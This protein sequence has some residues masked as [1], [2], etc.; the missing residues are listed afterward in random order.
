MNSV[1]RAAI[2]GLALAGLFGVSACNTDALSKREAVVHFEAGA[3]ASDHQAVLAACGHVST[4]V[5][6]EPMSTSSLPSD[7]V[8]NVRFRID[9]ANDRE[10]NLLVQCI[11]KQPGVNGWD[12]PDLTN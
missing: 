8:G 10:L 1:R 9:H 2:A 6:P 3:P 5:V 12:I 7:A 11:D 4:N